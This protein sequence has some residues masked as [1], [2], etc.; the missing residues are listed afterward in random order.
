MQH[1][2]VAGDGDLGA[3]EAISRG[4]PVQRV[5]DFPRLT[6]LP[7]PGRL[8]RIAQAMRDYH[9]VLSYGWGAIDAALAHTLFSELY[10]LP[11]LIHHEDGSDETPAQQRRLGRR[12]YRRLGLGKSVGLVVPTEIMEAVALADWQQPLGRVKTIR[13]GVDLK[14]FGRRARPDAIPRLLKRPGEHWIGYVMDAGNEEALRS[15]LGTLSMLDEHWH[16]VVL[17]DDLPL[18]AVPR[19]LEH[20]VRFVPA[21]PDRAA[22]MALFDIVVVAGSR[23]PLPLAAIEAM[24]AGKPLLGLA[25]DEAAASFAPD[26]VAIGDDP[27]VRLAGDGYLRQTIGTANREKARAERDEKTMIAAYQRLYASA[28]RRE[29]V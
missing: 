14:R 9:L 17:G 24:A 5:T 8:Q 20:R 10:G 19:P 4:I 12:W 11:P 26:T 29:T 23:E 1:Y 2:L 13:D 25:A 15:L 21:T 3:L 6:G 28:M 18:G 16:L 22:A 27:L 7:L